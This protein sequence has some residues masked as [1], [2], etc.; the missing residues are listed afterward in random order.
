M[1][2]LVDY[3]THCSTT[4][5]SFSFNLTSCLVSLQGIL[6]AECKILHGINV[7]G[8]AADDHVQNINT[9]QDLVLSQENAPQ[10]HRTTRQIERETGASRRTVG[11]IIHEDVHLKCLKKRI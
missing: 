1:N 4:R 8:Q 9:V 3:S 10:T 2:V 7:V 6:L 11:R 5:S